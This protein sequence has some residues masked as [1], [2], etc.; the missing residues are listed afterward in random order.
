MKVLY[1]SRINGIPVVGTY[2]ELVNIIQK[3]GMLNHPIV[4][5]D[6]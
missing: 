3:T 5:L 6:K 1:V 4:K 2:Q